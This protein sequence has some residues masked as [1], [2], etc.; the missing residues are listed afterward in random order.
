MIAGGEKNM[1]VGAQYM[2]IFSK[3]GIPTD[4]PGVEVRYVLGG[5]EAV[6]AF[7]LVNAEYVHLND[8]RLNPINYISPM[9]GFGGRFRLASLGD[10]SLYAELGSKVGP[11]FTDKEGTK[12]QSRLE[13]ALGVLMDGKIPLAFDFIRVGGNWLSRTNENG[14][15]DGVTNLI[16]TSGIRY[17]F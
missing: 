8:G 11:T 5:K 17:R 15:S 9:V 1:E 2:S 10:E 7:G 16:L 6:T 14:V 4:S 3:A 12:L 13:A